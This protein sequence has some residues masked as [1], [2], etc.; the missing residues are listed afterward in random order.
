MLGAGVRFWHVTDIGMMANHVRFRGLKWT[1]VCAQ[2]V[3]S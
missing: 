2:D 1:S 3:P